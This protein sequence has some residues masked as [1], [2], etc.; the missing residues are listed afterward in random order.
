M[1]KAIRVALGTSGQ[2]FVNLPSAVLSKFDRAPES[3]RIFIKD[4]F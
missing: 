4:R 1:T 2:K 3:T